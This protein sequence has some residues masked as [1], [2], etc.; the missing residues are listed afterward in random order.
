MIT[1][2]NL[3]HRTTVIPSTLRI[4]VGVPNV[5]S[6]LNLPASLIA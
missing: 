1:L 2:A 5:C 4:E 3:Q 6:I